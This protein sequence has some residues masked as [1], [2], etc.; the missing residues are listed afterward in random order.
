MY[1]KLEN[2]HLEFVRHNQAQ[3]RDELYQGLMD[4]MHSRESCAANVGCRVILPPSFIG[5][6]RDMKKRYLNTMA[7][8][9]RYGKPDIFLTITCNANWIEIKQEL[10]KGEHAQ[11]RPDLVSRIFRVKLVIL[12][13]IIW[14]KKISLV[15]LL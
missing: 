1:V 6:P 9:Q 14:G 15:K 12:K 13:N 3:L 11:D 4:T 10:S 8:V 5:G 2:N 7:L